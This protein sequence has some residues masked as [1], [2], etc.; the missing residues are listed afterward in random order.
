M[1]YHKLWWHYT[2][3]QDGAQLPAGELGVGKSHL[4][5]H[6]P[7]TGLTP[8]AASDALA[9]QVPERTGVWGRGPSQGLATGQK[10]LALSGEGRKS[11]PNAGQSLLCSGT[12][13]GL[14]YCL[15]ARVL[16]ALRILGQAGRRLVLCHPLNG[17]LRW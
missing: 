4:S 9:P 1:R 2:Q 10:G 12:L 8:W 16:E 13:P 15:R 3:S 14:T 5:R 17:R 6:V 11:L 7:L